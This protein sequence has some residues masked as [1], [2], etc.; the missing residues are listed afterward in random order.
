MSRRRST[1]RSKTQRLIASDCNRIAR[2]DRRTVVIVEG[3]QPPTKK[4]DGFHYTTRT[5][6]PVR[7][8]SSYAKIGWSSLCYHGST[9]RIEVGLEWLISGGYAPGPRRQVA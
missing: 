7:H 5:G 1:Y 2:A 3:D 9:R 8:P 6:I 4:G